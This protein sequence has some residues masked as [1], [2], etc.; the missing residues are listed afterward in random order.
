MPHQWLFA[1]S[2]QIKRIFVLNSPCKSLEFPTALQ[3]NWFWVHARGHQDQPMWMMAVKQVQ[4]TDEMCAN[5]DHY[6]C[7]LRLVVLESLQHLT[8]LFHSCMNQ[9]YLDRQS[10]YIFPKSLATRNFFSSVNKN[11]RYVVFVLHSDSW[12]FKYFPPPV[13]RIALASLYWQTIF[14]F[15]SIATTLVFTFNNIHQCQ[16][17][18]N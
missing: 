8:W 16:L 15:L 12:W 13:H 9:T 1:T 17:E 14:L 5:C 6:W 3:E 10:S 4:C 2:P 7:Q 18:I 11:S